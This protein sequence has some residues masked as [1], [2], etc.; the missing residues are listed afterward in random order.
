LTLN[1]QSPALVLT[2]KNRETKHIR[3]TKDN[4]KKVR[5]SYNKTTSSRFK[6]M[7]SP[8]G[9]LRLRQMPWR[10]TF[11]SGPCCVEDLTALLQTYLL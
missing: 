6:L 1:R 7:E 11:H 4:Q 2:T 8:P 3:N 5:R 9:I 10:L